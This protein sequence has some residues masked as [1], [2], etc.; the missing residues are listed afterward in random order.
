VGFRIAW[1]AAN[2]ADPL[3]MMLTVRLDFPELMSQ[4]ISSYPHRGSPCISGR[5]NGEFS[6]RERI[7]SES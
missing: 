7:I 4:R 5:E 1:V 6:T 3:T 2:A